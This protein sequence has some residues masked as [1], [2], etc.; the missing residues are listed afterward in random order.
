MAG[1]ERGAQCLDATRGRGLSL[2]VL[3]EEKRFLEYIRLLLL[4]FKRYLVLIAAWIRRGASFRTGSGCRMV[5]TGPEGKSVWQSKAWLA[6]AI[7]A[8]EV[9]FESLSATTFEGLSMFVWW[10]KRALS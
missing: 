2:A 4:F 7:Y 3:K 10:K 5:E 8:G 9:V 1:E 6:A